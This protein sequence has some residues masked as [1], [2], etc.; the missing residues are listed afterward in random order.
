[1]FTEVSLEQAGLFFKIAR[2]TM[3]YLAASEYEAFGLD[4]TTA[5]SWITAASGLMDAHCRRV[6]L[7]VAQYVERAR[8]AA[9]SV[10]TRLTFLPLASVEGQTSA[11]SKIRVRYGSARRSENSGDLANDVASVFALPGTWTEFPASAVDV[12][13][14]S[15]ELTIPANPL[16]L[17][18]NE[19]EVTYTAGLAPIP[20]GVKVACAQ[21]ARNAQAMP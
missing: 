6:T 2:G 4:A 10:T 1:M 3:D 19:I 18:F 15:G 7:G 12:D 20:D 13:V 21:I 8:L 14:E 17:S 5:E 16:G 11:I 9:G